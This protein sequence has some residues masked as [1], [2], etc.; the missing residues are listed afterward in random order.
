MMKKSL[1]FLSVLGLVGLVLACDSKP[2]STDPGKTPPTGRTPT[3]PTPGT[4]VVPNPNAPKGTPNHWQN[5]TPTGRTSGVVSSSFGRYGRRMSVDQ[6]RRTIPKLFGGLSW[7][8]TSGTR[9]YNRFDTLARTLG[10]ADYVQ[11]NQSTRDATSLFMKF[12]DDMAGT[13]CQK[14]VDADMKQKDLTKRHVIRYEDTNKTL[15]FL[16]LKFHAIWVP[17]TSTEGIKQLRTLYD[18]A[19]EKTKSESEAWRGVCIALLTA[20]EFFAY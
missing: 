1:L 19:L 5:S 2:T 17:S 10:E 6:L 18:K 9:T 4:V 11:V 20:P 15:R 16:R 14:A 12:M 7:T 8:Y 13:V 3:S